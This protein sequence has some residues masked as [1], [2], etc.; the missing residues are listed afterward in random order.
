MLAQSMSDDQVVQY[1][2]TA[3]ESGKTQKEITLDLLKRGVT[4]EQVVRIQQKYQTQQAS[5]HAVAT[6]QTRLRSIEEEH[7]DPTNPIPL[8]SAA[9]ARVESSTQIFGHNLFN[10]P[11]LTFEPSNNQP[12]PP[13]YRLGPGDEVV[14]DI[15]GASENTIRNTISAEGSI[16]VA[17]L[18][19][20]YLNGMTIKEANTYLQSEFSKI[21][22]GISSNN[23]NSQ[24]QL[25]LGNIRSIQVNIMGEVRTPGTYTLSSFSTVFHAL[26]RSGGVNNIGTLRSIKIMR[27]G[28]LLADLDVYQYIMQGKM[29]D[30][31]HLQDGYVIIVDPYE[32]LVQITGKVKR[33]MFYEL[34]TTETLSDLLKYAGGFTGDAYRNAIRV[35]RKSARERQVYNID[36]KDFSTFRL[37]DGDVASI[38]ATLERYENR[39][40]VNGAVYR[41]GLYQLNGEVNTVKSLI[42]KAEGVTGDAALDQAQL[43]REN[44]DLTHQMIAIDLRG[45]LNGSVADIPLQKNDVLY[46]PGIHDLRQRQTI[47]IHGEVPNPGTFSYADKT[48]INDL[49]TLAGGLLEAAATVNVEVTRRIKSP[50]SKEASST[51]AET[52]QFDLGLEQL[53]GKEPFYLEPFD[54]V[55]IRRSPAYQRQT[56]VTINGEVLFGGNY[57]LIKKNE[58]LSDLVNRAGGVTPDAYVKGARLIRQRNE[59]EMRREQDILRIAQ[60]TRGGQGDS[61]SV[62]K[63]NILPSY[64]VGINLVEALANP[65]SDADLTLREGDVLFIPEYINTVKISGSVLYPNTV[66]YK[67]GEKLTYYVDQAGGYDSMA[68]KSKAYVIYLNGTVARIKKHHSDK[69]APGCEII[70]PSKREHRRTSLAEILAMGTS[71]ASLAT[72]VATITNLVKK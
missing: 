1:V 29:N 58:R 66:F 9:P 44:E 23:P 4:K 50:E 28:K 51:M 57:A 13:N 8:T 55:Y 10:N 19:P 6:E 47:S 43:D 68:K 35:I 59:E 25:T 20:V 15:W 53:M 49:I 45:I 39:I 14:I 31:V 71:F 2:K 62:A 24:I 32:E 67:S 63:L 27:A 38:D 64:T 33:P 41:P 56:N 65:G 21:Y 46:I 60:S 61:L 17:G 7:S 11:R 37:S 36:E 72:M 34:K 16:F 3:H 22:S 70:I 5:T 30:D 42:K 26:Y 48:T 54:E 69:V 12:T 52:Y 18:G 40:E